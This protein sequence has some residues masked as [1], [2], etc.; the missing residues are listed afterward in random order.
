MGESS[1][2]AEAESGSGSRRAE[3]EE[4]TGRGTWWWWRTVDGALR[5]FRGRPAHGALQELLTDSQ[6]RQPTKVKVR[7]PEILLW[8]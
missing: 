3:G 7:T 8:G 6:D 4:T 1:G 2:E 5:F